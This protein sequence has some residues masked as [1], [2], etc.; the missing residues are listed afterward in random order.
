[1]EGDFKA[2]RKGRRIKLFL[3][4]RPFPFTRI[5]RSALPSEGYGDPDGHVDS[6]ARQL[7]FRS[8][9]M[10]IDARLWHTAWASQLT[11]ETDAEAR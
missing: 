2:E 5:T 3:I 6:D 9:G 4:R 11:Q 10:R 8:R 1:M 7:Q